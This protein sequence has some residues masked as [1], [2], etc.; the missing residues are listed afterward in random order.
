LCRERRS[1]ECQAGCSGLHR[2]L[3]LA[4]LAG[5]VDTD[6]SI[7]RRGGKD[8][9]KAGL[10]DC[11]GFYTARSVAPEGVAPVYDLEVAGG[12]VFIAD[13]SSSNPVICRAALPQGRPWLGF[14][15]SPSGQS[16]TR[17]N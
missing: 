12:Y 14:R 13:G 15:G 3:R 17:C 10:D 7:D 1:S 2:E 8:A 16:A 11:L 6:G 9:A 4:F 5:L